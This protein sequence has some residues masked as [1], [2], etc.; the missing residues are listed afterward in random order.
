MAVVINA[1]RAS[2]FYFGISKETVPGTPVAPVT[3]PRWYNGTQIEIDAKMQR[4][5]EG[6]ASRRTALIIKNGQKVKIKLVSALRPNELGLFEQ[7][8]HGSGSDNYTAPT[9]STTM[10]ALSSAGATTIS[11]AANT[12]LTG[13]GTIPL[14]IGAGTN[15]EEIAVFT[16]PPTG[17]GPYTLT[18]AGGGTLK[19]AHA[20]ASTVKSA[21]THAITDQSD[22][23]YFTI[24]C[25]IGNLFGAGGT[26]LR[27]RSCKVNSFKVSSKS[28]ELLMHEIEFIGIASTVQGSPATVTSEQHGAFLFTQSVWTLDGS[29]TGDAPNLESFEIE[30][31]NLLDD[32]IQT[33]QLTLAALIFGGDLEIN[34]KYT[35]AFTSASR[36]FLAYFGGTGGTTDAQALGLGALIVT[37]T[38]PDTLNTLTYTIL[39]LGYLKVPPPKPKDDG[40]HYTLDVEGTSVA[41]P[42]SGAGPNN[43]YLLQTTLVNTQYGAY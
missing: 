33:E 42:L 2:N 24:E 29:T 12:G 25:G 41:A 34:A 37:F 6:D 14:V 43:P 3:F 20:N 7:A 17:S 38:Q 13:A 8:A 22:G 40:K 30:R 1:I 35:L 26:A 27:V 21:A 10:S 5:K 11:V 39:T 18:V 31:K 19:L 15:S 32:T 36:I 16:T 28:G 9:V 4:I 23:D